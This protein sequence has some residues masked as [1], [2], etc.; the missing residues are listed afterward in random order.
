MAAVGAAPQ[1]AHL[2]MQTFSDYLVLVV[3]EKLKVR[4]NCKMQ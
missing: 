3:L 1:M 4:L 2:T